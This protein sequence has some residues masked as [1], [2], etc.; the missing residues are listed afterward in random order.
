M[1]GLKVPVTELDH[2]EG[3]RDAPVV[4]VEYGDF[5]C[6]YCAEAHFKLQKLLKEFDKNIQLVFRNFPLT[7][8]HPFAQMAAESVEFASAHKK[9]WPLHNY[10][11]E[12]QD[13]L[14][15]QFLLDGVE[16]LGLSPGNLLGALQKGTYKEVVKEQFL[17]GVK[18]GVNGTPTLF[19]NNIRYNGP[20]SIQSLK[21]YISTV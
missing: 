15:E 18:S 3:N 9:F 13:D 10:I 8:I 16:K 1:T 4:I 19:F 5:E 12:N 2:I 7:Q 14:S 11:F 20:M 6:P 21:D 17:G